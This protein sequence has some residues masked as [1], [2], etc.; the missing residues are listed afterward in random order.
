MVRSPVAWVAVE[1]CGGGSGRLGP[2]R[3]KTRARKGRRK[4]VRT[5]IAVHASS[6]RIASFWDIMFVCCWGFLFRCAICFLFHKR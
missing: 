5:S 3:K 6:E 1:V 4:N 2:L